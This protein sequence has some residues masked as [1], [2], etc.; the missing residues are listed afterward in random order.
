MFNFR[1]K[2]DQQTVIMNATKRKSGTHT[3]NAMMTALPSAQE[4]E[5]AYMTRDGSYD[6]IFYLAVR[7]TGI[8]CRPSCPATFSIS[9]LRKRR[10]SPDTGRASGAI[11]FLRQEPFPRG[12]RSCFPL[13][14]TIRRPGIPT[15]FFARRE[16]IRPGRGGSFRT[17]TA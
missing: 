2:E 15:V 7:S 4:M 13:L 9:R 6:G 12:R 11:R 1:W 17:P 10:S 16:S 5:R 3:R 8:F 14:R